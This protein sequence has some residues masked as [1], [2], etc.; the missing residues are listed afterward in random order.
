MKHTVYTLL[1]LCFS[2]QLSAQIHKVISAV[3]QAGLPYAVITNN[4]GKGVYADEHGL[5]NISNFGKKDSL[6]I[7]CVGYER[8]NLSVATLPTIISLQPLTQTMNEVVIKSSVPIKTIPYPKRGMPF[9][10]HSRIGMELATKVGFLPADAGTHKKLTEVRIRIKHLNEDNPCRLHIYEAT[11]ADTPGKELM[12]RDIILRKEDANR[13][14]FYKDLS[15]ENIYLSADAVFIGIEWIGMKNKLPPSAPPSESG[16]KYYSIPPD[17]RMTEAIP[18]IRTYRR[19][20]QHPVWVGLKPI[21]DA[22]NPP[23]M[24]VSLS[25]Q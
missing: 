22:D 19:L 14:A 11:T 17:L 13:I 16:N 2:I 18:E 1:L 8:T 15:G 9:H 7:Y 20:L 24:V 10:W 6:S 5:F 4:T 3:T 25:Y 21:G 12:M 23:N